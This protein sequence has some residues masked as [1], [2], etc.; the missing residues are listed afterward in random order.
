MTVSLVLYSICNRS[1]FS[2]LSNILT[3]SGVVW[4]L[5]NQQGC[6]RIGLKYKKKLLGEISNSVNSAHNAFKE[7]HQD[8]RMT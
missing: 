1:R 3:K 5:T 8:L 6:E 7:L 4:I 2:V